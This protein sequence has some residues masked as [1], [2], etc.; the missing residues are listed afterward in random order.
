MFT[1]ALFTTAKAWKQPK[2]AQTDAWLK[3]IWS[4]H[5]YYSAIKSEILTL[6]TW[7]DLENI[8]LSD[9]SYMGNQKQN[10]TNKNPAHREKSGRCQRQRG[11]GGSG[12]K[13]S[14]GTNL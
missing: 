2:C 11:D 12:W 4:L 3:K 5:K 1:A 9:F 14:K 10:K 7:M 6:A 8:M 13:R